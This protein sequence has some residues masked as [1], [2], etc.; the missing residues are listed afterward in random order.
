M[1]DWNLVPDFCSLGSV[2]YKGNYSVK[3]ENLPVKELEALADAFSKIYANGKQK[4]F[5]ANM[6]EAQL[7]ADKIEKR[8]ADANPE[9]GSYEGNALDETNITVEPTEE[10]VR[11][12][13]KTDCDDYLK[14]IAVF[15]DTRHTLPAVDQFIHQNMQLYKHSDSGL[16]NGTESLKQFAKSSKL[17]FGISALY[18]HNTRS[19]FIR[20]QTS[21][22]GLNY[23]AQ[24]PLIMAVFKKFGYRGNDVPYSLWDKRSLKHIVP[25]MLREALEYDYSD[26]NLSKED[27][28]AIRRTLF[29]DE[30]KCN[31]ITTYTIYGKGAS[32]LKDVPVLGCHML[33][34][35]WACN[36]SHRHKYMILDPIDWEA[37][38]EPIALA[39]INNIDA[40]WEE[41]TS[42]P[43]NNDIPW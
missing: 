27:L 13:V 31:P 38:P 25:Q 42:K 43:V 16:V 32:R 36:P 40:M 1:N 20:S 35:T 4:A 6:K 33:L 29:R 26:L 19:C 11:N 39:P 23:C 28:T 15:K 41:T 17:A 9:A 37:F 21:K 24:V 2:Y 3:N 22:D 34:Q 18:G 30:P 8:H 7:A 14:S 5:E 10:Q 12:L